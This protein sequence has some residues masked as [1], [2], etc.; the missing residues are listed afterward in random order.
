MSG[1]GLT[2]PAAGGGIS[3]QT[4]AFAAE[5]I[6]RLRDF[7]MFVAEEYIAVRYARAPFRLLDNR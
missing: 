7:P 5:L 6:D 1:A 4:L 3:D 2:L